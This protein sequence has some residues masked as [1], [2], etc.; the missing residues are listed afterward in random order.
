M[1]VTDGGNFLGYPSMFLSVPD[2]HGFVMPLAFQSI[3][4]SLS[5]GIGAALAEP[6]RLVIAAM[7]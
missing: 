5:A 6:N 1:V 2:G 4:L 3:G 7:G